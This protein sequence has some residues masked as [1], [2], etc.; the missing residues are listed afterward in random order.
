M[1]KRA[2]AIIA[3]LCLTTAAVGATAVTMTS[4]TQS[5]SA[6]VVNEKADGEVQMSGVDENADN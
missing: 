3:A 5:A 6:E 4:F 1:K 2:Y